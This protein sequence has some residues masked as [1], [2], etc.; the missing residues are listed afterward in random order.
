MKKAVLIAWLV[1]FT[2][3]S[4]AQNLTE[5]QLKDSIHSILTKSNTPGAFVTV[6]SGDSILFQSEFGSSDAEHT[7]KVTQKSLFALGS[8]SKTFT[9]LAIMKLVGEG[10]L[11]LEDELK[12]IAP[13]V[14]FENDWE[15]SHPVKIKH[16]LSHRSGF[17][18]MHISAIIKKREREL[19]ALDEVMTFEQSYQS[20]WQPGLVFSYSNPGYVILGYI[21]EKT[22]GIPYQEYITKNVLLPLE[23][24]NTAYYSTQKNTDITTGF[25]RNNGKIESSKAPKLIGES[26][27]GLVS[28]S[29]DMSKF[30]QFFLNENKLDSF[31]IITREQAAIMQQLQSNFEIEN[32]ISTGYSLGMCDKDYGQNDV[33]FKGHNGSID[34]FTSDYIF[35]QEL[36]LGMAVS[37][38]LFQ[39]S[40]SKILHLLVDHFVDPSLTSNSKA[41][42]KSTD[43]STYKEWEGTYKMLNGTNGLANLIN[44]PVRT[45]KLSIKNNSLSIKRF[46]RDEEVYYHSGNNGF[47]P[48]KNEAAY[49]FLCNNDGEKAL[50]FYEDTFV[51]INPL[52]HYLSTGLLCFGLLSGF[53]LT[54]LFLGQILTLPFT[55]T[56]L[57]STKTTGL[58]ALPFWLMSCSIAIYLSNSSFSNLESL[59]TVTLTSVSLF[60]CSILFPVFSVYGGFKLYKK[61]LLFKTNGFKVFYLSL[62]AGVSMFTIYSIY[63]GWFDLRLWSI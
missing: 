57:S 8:I 40:N 52:A 56:Y 47:S 28:C 9:A 44:A 53:L 17:D 36:N 6:V 39:K 48:E 22:S 63:H 34:G 59:G 12:K 2:F 18:D 15:S 19:T 13:E 7:Q 21:I 23:M 3:Q 31:G 14:P 62:Y 45:M 25:Q 54:M 46:I 58:M 35:N 55:R 32:H 41:P 26:A 30:L 1:T 51:K 49:L 42:I 29:S 4:G 33:L 50:V 10:K 60:A 20:N 24:E 43:I 11:S 27:G 37:S 16:L 61:R 38:N 5:T